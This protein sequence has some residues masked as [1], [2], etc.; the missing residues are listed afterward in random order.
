MTS[1]PSVTDPAA[2]TGLCH[3]V[4]F[5]FDEAVRESVIARLSAGLDALVPSVAGLV[6]YRHG[7]D[8]G[9]NDGNADYAVAAVFET[10]ALWREYSVLPEHRKVIEE[11]IL[12]NVKERTSVQFAVQV[13]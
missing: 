12:P 8:L 9:F 5:R 13:P 2:K 11:I 3:V 4:A 6:S 7:R 1:E 10:E